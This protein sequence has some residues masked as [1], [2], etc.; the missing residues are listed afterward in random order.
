MCKL[1]HRI[2]RDRLLHLATL[3]GRGTC[4]GLSAPTSSRL[5]QCSRILVFLDCETNKIALE[6]VDV[7]MQ[8]AQAQSSQA[9]HDSKKLKD[10]KKKIEKRMKRAQKKRDAAQMDYSQSNNTTKD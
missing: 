5:A 6:L 4:N 3:Y 7:A 2:L 10:T 9:D 1:G 8:L